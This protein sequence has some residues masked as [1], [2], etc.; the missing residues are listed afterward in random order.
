MRVRQPIVCQDGFGMS[1]QASVSHYC[2]PRDDKGPYS[3]VEVGFPTAYEELLRAYVEPSFNDVGETVEETQWTES[4][5]GYVPVE[6]VSA[7]IEKHGGKQKGELP[8]FSEVK[9]ER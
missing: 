7:V 4:V 2:S 9:H 1:V 6:V 8:P 3:A 5:Y